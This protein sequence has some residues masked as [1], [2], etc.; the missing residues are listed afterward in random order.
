[1]SLY[2]ARGMDSCTHFLVF[3]RRV[4]ELGPSSDQGSFQKAISFFLENEKHVVKKFPHFMEK[5]ASMSYSEE[6]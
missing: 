4:E 2:S 5:E 6:P 3:C 1:M